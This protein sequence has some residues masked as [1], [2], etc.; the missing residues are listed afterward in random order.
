MANSQN[1][2]TPKNQFNQIDQDNNANNNINNQENIEIGFLMDIKQQSNDNLKMNKPKKNN[3]NMILSQRMEMQNDFNEIDENNKLA[4]TQVIS[5]TKYFCD[6]NGKFNQNNIKKI[7]DDNSKKNLN[8]NNR[9]NMSQQVFNN[10]YSQSFNN[11]NNLKQY[12]NNLG[13]SQQISGTKNNN[14]I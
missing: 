14:K 13:K 5:D 1:T 2:I 6:L 11:N 3:N 8:Q 7:N 9:I 10:N 12:Y 4:R